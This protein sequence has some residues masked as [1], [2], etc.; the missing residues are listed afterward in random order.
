MSLAGRQEFYLLLPVIESSKPAREAAGR[1]G[2]YSPT[3]M[4]TF[5]IS[6]GF[7]T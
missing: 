4:R 7:H 5:A 6:A 2:A 1:N 3:Y